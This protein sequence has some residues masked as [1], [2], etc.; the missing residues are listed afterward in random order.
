MILCKEN[1]DNYFIIR[2]NITGIISNTHHRVNFTGESEITQVKINNE[3]SGLGIVHT[4]LML[5]IFN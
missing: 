4:I 1:T 5:F 3:G 2:D